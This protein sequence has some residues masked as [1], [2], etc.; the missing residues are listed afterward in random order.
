MQTH[1]PTPTPNPTP[2]PPAADWRAQYLAD[3]TQ[4][5]E[6]HQRQGEPAQDLQLMMTTTGRQALI[7]AL[8]A[9]GSLAPFR[10]E[11]FNQVP[12]LQY[13]HLEGDADWCLVAYYGHSGQRLAPISGRVPAEAAQAPL[14]PP[15]DPAPH[16]P[17]PRALLEAID[18]AL[19]VHLDARHEL[20]NLRLYLT[21]ECKQVLEH[22]LTD[23]LANPPAE[24]LQCMGISTWL[25]KTGSLNGDWSLC[26]KD[27]ATG[28][29]GHC[30][31]GHLNGLTPAAELEMVIPIPTRQEYEDEVPRGRLSWAGYISHLVAAALEGPGENRPEFWAHPQV[32]EAHP[33]LPF[34]HG[35]IDGV[36]S[37]G[38]SGPGMPAP[39]T[40]R[41]GQPAPTRIVIQLVGKAGG[42]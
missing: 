19:M 14:A 7:D 3:I 1:S 16:T 27:P 42:Q 40:L 37:A 9:A 35:T 18:Q 11:R 32:C 41:P 26:H 39:Y 22:E 24:P 5:I 17:A 20:K 12:V 4:A 8:Q 36:P 30:I 25:K 29:L 38:C 28:A 2:N 21:P 34:P 33:H 10:N 31:S 23:R 6:T 13:R 15:R